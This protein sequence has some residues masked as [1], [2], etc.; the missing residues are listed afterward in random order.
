MDD[1]AA[2]GRARR[3]SRDRVRSRG[4]EALHHRQRRRPLR[5]VGRPED[6]PPLHESSALAVLSRGDRQRPPVLPRLWRRAGQRDDLRT[7]AHGQP[8]RDQDERL[9]Q[10]RWRRRLPGPRRPR[11]SQHRLHAV[12]GRRAA[13]ARFADRPEHERP[14]LRPQHGRWAAD[15]STA[16]RRNGWRTA[17]GT[18]RTGRR[19]RRPLRPLAVGRSADRQPARVAAALLRGR[20][21]VSQRRSWR[22]VDRHQPRPHAS[23]RCDEN[24]DHGKSLAA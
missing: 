22:L 12:T 21:R 24:P 14:P 3:S 2:A 9:D 1:G 18:W 19:A 5:V 17:G 8:R 11:R 7:V 20:T 10:R 13:A 6:L 23:A 4:S 16:G 15:R